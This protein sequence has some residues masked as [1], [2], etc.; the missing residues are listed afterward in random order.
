MTIAWLTDIHLNF[1]EA[2]D[3]REILSAMAQSRAEVFIITG[4]IAESPSLCHYLDI[5]AS[6]LSRP[7]YFVLGNH[8]YYAGS[9][10]EMRRQ[11]LELA[12]KSPYLCFLSASEVIHLT[13]RTCLVGH[14]GWAD[15]RLGDYDHS[16]VILSDWLL[17]EEFRRLQ[18]SDIGLDIDLLST[19]AR[20]RRLELLQI[21]AQEA[22][23]H[24]DR[25]IPKALSAYDHIMVATHVPPFEQACWYAGQISGPEFLPHFGNRIVGEV[26]RRHMALHPGRHMTVLC[27]HTHGGGQTTILPN[28]TVRTGGA[29]YGRPVIQEELEID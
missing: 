27:G 11:S 19:V 28:L 18:E 17:I 15:G 10:L 4:D 12:S 3:L 13:P 26:L 23:E 25:V 1:V 14:D 20:R 5:L 22:A 24:L 6:S 29:S 16:E 8:D 9:I 7:L 21:L 2:A